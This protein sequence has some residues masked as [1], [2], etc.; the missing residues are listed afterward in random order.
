MHEMKVHRMYCI[1]LS[2]IDCFL[3]K[4]V[5]SQQFMTLLHGMQ[6]CSAPSIGKPSCLHE[7]STCDD[8][9]GQFTVHPVQVHEPAMTLDLFLKKSGRTWPRAF[10]ERMALA[11][12]CWHDLELVHLDTL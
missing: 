3:I 11:G 9:G 10:L 8:A 5:P 4:H 2:C 1:L 7:E 12:G 6:G